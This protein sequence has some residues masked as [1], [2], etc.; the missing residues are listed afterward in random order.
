MQTIQKDQK[1]SK[2]SKGTSV[3]GI[4]AYSTSSVSDVGAILSNHELESVFQKPG[5]PGVNLTP[6]MGAISGATVFICITK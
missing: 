5:G 3:A 1:R 4:L 6:W 2:G